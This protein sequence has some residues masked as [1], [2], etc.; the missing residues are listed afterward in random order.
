MALE[1]SRTLYLD[2]I[3]ELFHVGQFKHDK[4][5]FINGYERLVRAPGLYFKNPIEIAA[6][7]YTVEEAK[8]IGLTSSEITKYL[9]VPWV[10]QTEFKVFL[11]NVGLGRHRKEQA[12]QPID[13]HVQISRTAPISLYHFVDYFKGFENVPGIKRSLG[14][15]AG[16][17]LRQ[18]KVEFQSYPLDYLRMNNADGHLEV[19][20][21]HLN[22]SD[23]SV[24]YLD[25]FLYLQ[26]ASQFL[27]G[28]WQVSDFFIDSSIRNEDRDFRE[29]AARAS[30]YGSY[31]DIV[32]DSKKDGFGF[33]DTPMA[34]EAYRATVDE[35]R[36]I[37][38]PENELIE[39]LNSPAYAMTRKAQQR[40]MRNL[41]V[42]ANRKSHESNGRR[43]KS[44]L[45][46]RR[47]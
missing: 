27:L 28:R 21:W 37:G 20:L 7:N 30:G 36:R 46:V 22:D 32:T 18:L 6:Y 35:A 5:N 40:F 45:K 10:T 2:L 25:V 39:Y 17:K 34:I 31:S 12:V 3:H 19:S 1:E 29:Y 9:A 14:E 47:I 15:D 42:G 23:I 16:K 33:L 8:R 11:K 38:M 24:L 26:F 13:K 43:R 44:L 41:G 4:E